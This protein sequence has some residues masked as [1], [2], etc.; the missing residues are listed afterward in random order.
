MISTLISVTRLDAKTLAE[1]RI[2]SADVHHV[3]GRAMDRKMVLKHHQERRLAEQRLK[4]A[5]NILAFTNTNQGE[6]LKSRVRVLTGDAGKVLRE[7]KGVGYWMWRDRRVQDNWALLY[8]QKMA[9][10]LNVPLH[11]VCC[12]PPAFGE[13]TMRHYT[14]ML[15]GLKEV[16]EDHIT[17]STLS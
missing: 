7:C 14:F 3:P 15:E 2:H 16:A 6:G 4:T 8:A 5:D 9:L 13:M 1:R 17:H 10:E 12:V 11:V